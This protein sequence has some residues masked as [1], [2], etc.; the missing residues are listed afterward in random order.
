MIDT[1][2]RKLDDRG[3]TNYRVV[4]NSA[5]GWDVIIEANDGEY[6]YELSDV[7]LHTSPDPGRMVDYAID[8]LVESIER[9]KKRQKKMILYYDE[10][11]KQ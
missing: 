8:R 9:D 1:I 5:M 11:V 2:R 10:E 6:I 4:R 7:N 3:I